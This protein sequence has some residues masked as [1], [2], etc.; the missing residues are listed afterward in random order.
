MYSIKKLTHRRLAVLNFIQDRAKEQGVPPTLA[1]IA[2]ACGLV[3][4]SS[5]Q[6]H[7]K[8]LEAEGLIGVAA[9]QARGVRAIEQR[10]REGA[11]K[12][13]L[14]E[15]NS[16]DV[17]SLDDEA[18]RELVARMLIARFSSGGHPAQYVRWGG[19]QRAKD[20]G[21][22]VSVEAPA[23]TA[24]E[25][26]LPS[27]RIGIQVKA[28]SMPP[29]QVQREM[30]PQGVLRPFI[31]HLLSTKGAY[32]IMCSESVS[33]QMYKARMDAMRRAA[34]QAEQAEALVDF[35]DARRIADWVN[36]HPSV[37]AWL[38]NKVGRP[39]QG[40]KPFG[41]WAQGDDSG[42]LID[43]KK[44]R[45]YE[46]ESA[47]PLTAGLA[48]VRELLRN[49][50]ASVRIAGLSGVGK[51]RFAQALFEGSLSDDPLEASLAIYADISDDPE[52]SPQHLMDELVSN[53][54]HVVVVIDNCSSETHRQLTA[55]CR[56]STVSL[57]TIEYD[58]RDDLPD[59]T[60]VFRM[61]PA[62]E[63][64]V[65]E[66]LKRRFPDVSQVNIDTIKRIAD[67]N[68]RVAI[69]LANSLNKRDSLTAL[70]DDELFRRLFWQKNEQSQTLLHA[71][72]AAALVYSFDGESEVT[73]LPRIAAIAGLGVLE[74]YREVANLMARGLAQRRGVWRAVLPHAIANTLAKQALDGIPYSRIAREL[75]DGGGRLL[76]SFSRRL[77]YLHDSQKA[78]SI[79]REWL[80][81]GGILGD[82][83]TMDSDLYQILLN[84]A[85]VDPES[86][87]LAIERATEGPNAERFLSVENAR[88]AT[89]ARIVRSIAYDVDKFERCMA[90]LVKFALVEPPEH[91]SDRTSEL[92]KSLFPMYLS[93]THATREQR[94]EWISRSIRSQDGTLRTLA[95][96]CLDSAIE[97]HHFS[98]HYGFD[99]G[100][101]S[102]DY[103]LSPRS[104]EEAHGWF[105]PFITLA[106]EISTSTSPVSHQVRSVLARN[107]RSLWSLA[108]QYDLLEEVVRS[109]DGVQTEMF[110]LAIRQTLA[111]D[112]P[113]MPEAG[114]NRLLDLEEF[115][116]PKTLESKIRAVVLTS[117]G[118][119][120]DVTD[121]DE[122]EDVNKPHERA[123]RDAFRLG[124]L[125][126]ADLKFLQ[127]MLP[128]LMENRQGRHWRFGHGLAQGSDSLA[129][130]WGMLVEAFQEAPTESRNVQVLNGYL[131]GVNE[132][133]R[134]EFSEFMNQAM[135][136]PSLAQWVPLFQAG[137]GIDSEG[138]DRLMRCLEMGIA[139]ASAYQYL[140]YG[141]ASADLT[142]DQL[143]DILSRLTSIAGGDLVALD[144]L[145]L[146]RYGESLDFGPRLI[147]FGRMLL[148]ELSRSKHT[149]HTDFH[150][151][152]LMLKCL[153][154]VDGE[155]V[156][157]EI[158]KAIRHGLEDLTLSP[159]DI[160]DEIDALFE[161][162]PI[163]A[164]DILVGQ[165]DD[166]GVAFMRRRDLEKIDGSHPMSKIPATVLT[167]WAS[168]NPSRWV[169]L[170]ASVPALT[171]SSQD[172]GQANWSEKAV[173]LVKGAPSPW[174]VAE[175]LLE[176]IY[177]RSWIGSRARILQARL[178]LF[179]EML[180]LLPS[181]DAQKLED[182]RAY[183]LKV[184]DRE[185]RRESEEDRQ[186]NERFE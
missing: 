4:R 150:V 61:E 21:I 52:P 58:I 123:D 53:R 125:A 118:S 158:L 133:S 2:A 84:I 24:R 127:S 51:T 16:R 32:F 35:Y 3:S 144:V 167:E 68:S 64:L 28:T 48:R 39:L 14:F 113:G 101:R 9:G 149:D 27:G 86:V 103:G 29:K 119:G 31:R 156:A 147:E 30:C 74:T 44:E 170:A 148:L 89:V 139:P 160:D 88:R 106:I 25:L 105:K 96:E 19:D 22:D 176:R 157:R 163:A 185:R 180:R 18:L 42:A 56:S 128:E 130:V 165:E 57:L 98:S 181:T 60:D 171:Q 134:V 92:I 54:R 143:V 34:A 102:R 49:G 111:F 33:E 38:R 145:S 120:F 186:Q 100:V 36:E 168:K 173:S 126:A 179:E 172:D 10:P 17:E 115:S 161:V 124:K 112:K 5:A 23:S 12:N 182:K 146:H 110:W 62:S 75:V 37:V 117:F 97:A 77:G 151:K 121:G 15:V 141:R 184:I 122:D 164:L 99:F 137:V 132:K 104:R 63:E 169:A 70:R 90:V 76:R 107:F 91:K 72:Q 79:V 59:E 153:S 138:F 183:F 174:S 140:G 83:A 135:S 40:W 26:A 71:A 73:E 142:E 85:P 136:H 108:R 93:G 45:I 178:K 80:S 166:E 13:P 129:I 159:Y 43:D 8:A 177:P 131:F 55:K 87:L 69:A 65:D 82:L 95:V 154:G 116:R 162:Q 114:L 47:Y 20:G 46:N 155:P 78:V 109:M 6:K 41:S 175:L 1:E 50:G 94:V 66:L 152:R 11:T 7:V 67:G 81:H